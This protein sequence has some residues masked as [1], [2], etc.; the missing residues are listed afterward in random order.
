MIRVVARDPPSSCR[1]EFLRTMGDIPM[2]A[3]RARCDPVPM[4][5]RKRSPLDEAD[6]ASAAGALLVGDL[7]GA[8]DA[9]ERVSGRYLAGFLWRL[10]L[11]MPSVSFRLAWRLV[12]RRLR[13]SVR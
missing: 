6:G 10:G 4:G 12:R 11:L 8:V 5:A 1:V 7:E 3:P 9:L 13:G 2:D